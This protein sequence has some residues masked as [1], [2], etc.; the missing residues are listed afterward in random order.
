[1]RTGLKISRA[2]QLL[3]VLVLLSSCAVGLSHDSE[4]GSAKSLFIWGG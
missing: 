2:V 1:M 3:E 4:P